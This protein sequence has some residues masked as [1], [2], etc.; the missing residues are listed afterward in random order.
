[1]AFL[2]I[3]RMKDEKNYSESYDVN[4]SKKEVIISDKD[5]FEEDGQLFSLDTNG[6]SSFQD[7]FR[8]K[9]VKDFK[10]SSRRLKPNLT[11]VLDN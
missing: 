3:T 4:K 11:H 7:T 2:E 6:S 10:K 9:M 5:E 8:E 1:M